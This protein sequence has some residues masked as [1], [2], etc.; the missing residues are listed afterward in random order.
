MF[1]RGLEISVLLLESQDG[2]LILLSLC[3][4]GDPQ[5]HKNALRGISPSTRDPDRLGQP[6]GRDPRAGVEGK[7]CPIGRSLPVLVE[8]NKVG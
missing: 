1:A 5:L 7:G 8:M 2:N 3:G 6:S 4:P